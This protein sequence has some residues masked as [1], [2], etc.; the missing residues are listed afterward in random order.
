[1]VER[2][3]NSV[4]F[5]QP[6]LPIIETNSPRC[7]SNEISFKTRTSTGSKK[8]FEIVFVFKIGSI[9]IAL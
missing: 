6:D 8:D 5:P 2:I 4:D 1:M 3:Y 9:F 7:I